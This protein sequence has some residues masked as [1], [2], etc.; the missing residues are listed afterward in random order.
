MKT[1]L[2]HALRRAFRMAQFHHQHPGF[3]VQDTLAEYERQQLNRRE[4]LRQTALMGIGTVGLGTQ[5]PGLLQGTANP[6]IAIV[7]GGMAGLSA[8]YH[9][10]RRRIAAT[11]FEG[12]K[13][14]GGR[15]KSARIFGNGT[16]NTEIGAE[17]IDTLHSDMFY[18][19]RLLDLETTMMD[20]EQ[21]TMGI[22]DAFFI[23]GRHYTL[24]EVVK[25]F[26]QIYPRIQDDREQSEG[27]K[28]AQWD[29]MPMAEY[30][31]KLPV[32]P[33]VKKMLDAAYIGE[34]GM[35]TGEQSAL[36]LL[37]I[38]EIQDNQFFPF[39]SSDERFKVP[40]GNEKIPQGLAALLSEQLRYE[41]KFVSLKENHNDT[42]TL[43]FTVNGAPYSDTFDFVIMALPFSILR[44]TEL[45]MKLPK[46]KTRVI[47]ELGYGTNS[48]FI[49]ET[50]E[51]SWR[52]SGYRGYL[53]NERIHNGWDSTQMQ[54]NNEGMGTF[55]VYY[56][57]NR[58]KNAA[59]G[60]EQQQL[61]HI[62]P[63][64]EGAFPGTKAALTGKMEL[65]HWPGNPFIK[66]SYSCF[67]PGQALAFEGQ[68]FTPVRRLFFAG[69]HT[70]IEYWGFM[71]GAAETGKKAAQEVLRAVR[72]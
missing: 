27:K 56:G 31:E 39:G 32:S 58:G 65:A 36:N 72:V 19:A 7:G 10:R 14:V 18:F 68:A 38:F 13:R 2:L 59:K 70:S 6:K 50:R 37:S 35:E 54:Q 45:M 17:F 11:V 30:I 28:G 8:A 43:N 51:R 15:I 29:N 42:I 12:D 24:E 9:L 4:F 16:L 47:K 66:G 25:E 46:M 48:K 71:N 62:L 49:L 57:G 3:E 67:K 44:D 1:T 26:A 63:A 21:D 61:E 23:E 22:R 5:L 40:G 33:W 34:N 60:T 55:T 52:K 20:M 53:F 64:L 69:E 41:H